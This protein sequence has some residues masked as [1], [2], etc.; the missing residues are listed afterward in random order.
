MQC[1]RRHFC[2]CTNEMIWKRKRAATWAATV[3]HHRPKW[4]EREIKRLGYTHMWWYKV[5]TEHRLATVNRPSMT[6]HLNYPASLCSAYV[7]ILNALCNGFEL[8]NSWFSSSFFSSLILFPCSFSES[9][10]TFFLPAP[11]APNARTQL[12]TERSKKK[13]N[14]Y[15][16]LYIQ[17]WCSRC[18]HSML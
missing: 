5:S 2:I 15:M 14:L 12:K 8:F 11:E 4:R 6:K 9:N 10:S 17:W 18:S 7:L 16:H 13:M 3:A 1:A